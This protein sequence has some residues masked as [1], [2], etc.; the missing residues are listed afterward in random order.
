MLRVEFRPKS[1]TD[2][3]ICPRGCTQRRT[4]RNRLAERRTFDGMK[5]RR[6]GFEIKKGIQKAI[7]QKFSTV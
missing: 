4:R 2:L 7:F 6:C 3:T 5:C 1:R